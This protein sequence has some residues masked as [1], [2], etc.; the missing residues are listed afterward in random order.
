MWQ[1]GATLAE[2]M[3]VLAISA[4][5]LATGVP[6]MASLLRSNSLTA[7]TNEMLGS[8][9]LARSEAIKR[10]SRAVLCPSQDGSHCGGEGWHDGWLVFHD[11]N[12]N[13]TREGDEA[14]IQVHAALS[15]ELRL[16]GKGSMVA[17]ISYAETGGTK[18][19]SGAWQAGTLTVCLVA[20]APGVARQ[21]VIASTGRP[22][23]V[24]LNDATCL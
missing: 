18:V 11:A 3:V 20:A 7:A 13:A 5:L 12:N 17:Y 1:K 24:K 2:L 8:L 19:T 16:K 21:I 10:G 6:A 9:Q 14:L 23:V 22:R 15:G 4:I